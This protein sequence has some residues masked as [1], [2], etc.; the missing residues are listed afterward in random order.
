MGTLNVSCVGPACAAPNVQHAIHK[1]AI[2][3]GIVDGRQ[4][5][6]S[7]FTAFE[8][9][10]CSGVTFDTLRSLRSLRSGQTLNALWSLRAG[11]SLDSLRTLRPNVTGIALQALQAL[12]TRITGVPF[13][14]LQSLRPRRAG[15]TRGTLQ[16]LWAGNALRPRQTLGACGTCIP[17]V[18]FRSLWTRW[19]SVSLHTLGAWSTLR[20]LRPFSKDFD[21][22]GNNFLNDNK[23]VHFLNDDGISHG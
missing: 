11:F 15:Q 22:L 5:A 23:A 10:A 16:T 3:L 17:S 13:V 4:V 6:N 20:T 19:T 12:R 8:S 1:P 18:A 9:Q 2:T 21:N 7:R 14:A